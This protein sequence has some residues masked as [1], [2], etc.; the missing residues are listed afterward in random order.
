MTHFRLHHL[1]IYFNI[2]REWTHAR[3]YGADSPPQFRSEYPYIPFGIDTRASMHYKEMKHTI[4]RKRLL[5][6]KEDAHNS[7]MSIYYQCMGNWRKFIYAQQRAREAAVKHLLEI[8]PLWRRWRFFNILK[9]LRI[10]A[11][12]SDEI[13]DNNLVWI[14]RRAIRTISRTY[15]ERMN[16]YM[17]LKDTKIYKTMEF[18]LH[19]CTRKLA[20]AIN[21]WR[22]KIHHAE[23]IYK[24]WVLKGS[25]KRWRALSVM[26][27]KRRATQ[28]KITFEAWI[29]YK[30]GKR[31]WRRL[32]CRRWFKAWAALPR[33]SKVGF[34]QYEGVRHFVRLLERWH[35]RYQRACVRHGF[36][37]MAR[38]V[39]MT[40]Y[41]DKELYY[42]RVETR[43][44]NE[45]IH[46]H[47]H[48]AGKHLWFL[49]DGHAEEQV[50][51]VKMIQEIQSNE[52]AH[53]TKMRIEKEKIQKLLKSHMNGRS[54]DDEDENFLGFDDEVEGDDEGN[55]SG[56]NTGPNIQKFNGK[57]QSIIQKQ[58]K[59]EKSRGG[60]NAHAHSGFGLRVEQFVQRQNFQ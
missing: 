42:S 23:N 25:L 37:A 47:G 4:M 3:L 13:I 9:K 19:M 46:K 49:D 6:W 31:L 60:Y 51:E 26:F 58:R 40:P 2:Y 10:Y 12:L 38:L 55:G 34:R 16:K 22:I 44:R 50:Q 41:F 7:R 54:D 53:E 8:G 28:V 52:T 30:K 21:I 36:A 56:N 18:V 32:I 17:E 20:Y 35:E 43:H 29:I 15:D 1:S 57:W 45:A 33:C 39:H 27:K 59:F 48:G 11:R 24:E 5:E 14:Q